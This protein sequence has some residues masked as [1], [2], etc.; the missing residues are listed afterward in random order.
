V[1]VTSSLLLSV[2]L[3][4]SRAG[5]QAIICAP[6]TSIDVTQTIPIVL[7]T[8]P[9]TWISKENEGTHILRVEQ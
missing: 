3:V 4:G 7:H 8:T 1:Q 6:V 9:I 2:A 5:R